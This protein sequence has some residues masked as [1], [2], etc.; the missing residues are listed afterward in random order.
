M[1]RVKSL[2]IK[3]TTR[4]LLE[5]YSDAFAIDFEEN[6]KIIKRILPDVNKRTRNSIAGYI[7]RLKKKE[8]KIKK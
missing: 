6:K 4:Q 8:T 5:K 3:K 1:G 2:S 7:T